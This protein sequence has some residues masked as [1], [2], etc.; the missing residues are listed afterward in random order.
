MTITY[1]Y[2]RLFYNAVPYLLSGLSMGHIYLSHSHPIAICACPI[3]WDG[4]H[5]IPIGM[6]FPWTSLR[7]P[8]DS[9]WNDITMNKPAYC[10]GWPN[11]KPCKKGT[12][13]IATSN[14]NL[15]KKWIT[16]N[17][18]GTITYLCTV[19]EQHHVGTRYSQSIVQKNVALNRTNKSSFMS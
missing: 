8:W 7:F 14:D 1:F 4:S 16:F 2:T 3:P 5:G 11:S 13:H 19:Q 18:Y 15:K 9:H 17:L 6:T 10:I 12:Q